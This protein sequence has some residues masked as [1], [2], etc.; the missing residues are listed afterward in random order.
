VQSLRN[1]YGNAAQSLRKLRNSLRNRRAIFCAI[2]AQSLQNRFVIAAQSL[3]S[4]FAIRCAMIAQ[5]ATQ[6]S[7]NS[8]R[9]R[10]AI[11]AQSPRYHRAIAAQSLW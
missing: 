7:R 11:I 8:L 4:R 10:H 5:F 3:Q 9:N 6:S 1:R 2:A